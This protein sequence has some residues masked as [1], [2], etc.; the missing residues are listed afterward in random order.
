M[1]WLLVPVLLFLPLL[2]LA[3]GDDDGGGAGSSA[4]A[5]GGAVRA[6]RTPM[7]T[8]GQVTPTPSPT[9]TPTPRPD[10]PLYIA[11]GDSLSAGIGSSDPNHTSFVALVHKALGPDFGL[12]NLGVPGDTS[13]DLLYDGPLTQAIQEIGARRSDGIDGNEVEVVTLEIGGNDLLALYDDFVLTNEC[14][15]VPE[16]LERPVCVQALRDVLDRYE[17]NLRLVLQR[18]AEAD[19]GLPVFLMTLYN[20]FSGG[21]VNI[22]EIGELAL[23]GMPDTPFEDGL[24]DIVRRVGAEAGVEVVD[25]YPLFV[26][27]LG[28]YIAQDLI[29]PN[30]CGYA[31]TAGQFITA[32]SEA[33]FE[34]TEDFYSGRAFA[35]MCD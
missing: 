1:R 19:P 13:D 23:E 27:K 4:T 28:E 15:S 9:P 30:D 29:H 17:P 16:G 21:A 11:L 6:T 12:M 26:G 20:P 22:D 10:E 18:L 24:N 32:L 14:P 8:Q 2:T 33:G 35:A 31:V 7:R 34:V 3:C 25:V 5:S